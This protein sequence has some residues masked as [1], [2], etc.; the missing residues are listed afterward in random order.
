[1]ENQNSFIGMGHNPNP[2]VPDI[3]MGF[4]MGLFQQP[5]ARSFFERL[6]DDEK[7]RLIGYIQSSVSGEDAKRRIDTAIENLRAS[8]KSFF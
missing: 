2:N 5:Q 6:S 1:M 7:T 8:N 4:G 3:P